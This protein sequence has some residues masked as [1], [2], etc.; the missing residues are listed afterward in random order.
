MH[1]HRAH[2][3]VHH[4]V[5]CAGGP[6]SHRAILP[7]SHPAGFVIAAIDVLFLGCCDIIPWLPLVSVFDLPSP[8]VATRRRPSHPHAIHP[9]AK[10]VPS[11]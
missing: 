2:T 9:I 3:Q 10:A 7:G 1:A 11:V 8:R 5:F 4:V 6:A